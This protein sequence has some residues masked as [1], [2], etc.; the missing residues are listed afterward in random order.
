MRQNISACNLYYRWHT[1]GLMPDEIIYHDRHYYKIGCSDLNYMYRS[2]EGFYLS[3]TTPT[4]KY[5]FLVCIYNILDKVEKEY[6]KGIIGPFRDKILH[7]TKDTYHGNEYISIMYKDLNKNIRGCINLPS[8][9]PNTMYK[10]MKLDKD[11][12][13]DELNL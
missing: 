2:D 3:F 11:Y 4:F 12:T 6:L 9:K 10:G 1:G 7:I 13:L 8:F 5:S